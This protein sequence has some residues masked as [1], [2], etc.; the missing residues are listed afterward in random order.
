MTNIPIALQLYSVRGD[1]ENDLAATLKSVADLG[2]VGAEPWGYG[3]ESLDWMGHACQDIRAMYDDNGLTCCGIHLATGALMGDNL[4]RTIE[5]NRAL[6]NNFL[7][8]AADK[9][10]MSAVDTI[11]ELAGILNAAAEKVQPEGMF[12]GYHAHGF[13]F[14][15]V[16]GREPWDILFSSTGDDVI[17]QMDIGNCMGGGGDP[18]A[19]LRKFTNRARSLHLKDH[20]AP[21]DGVIGEGAADWEEIFRLVDTVQ[22]TEWFVVE[23]GGRDGHGF[24]VCRRSLEALRAMGK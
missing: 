8:I 18:V 15:K 16:A 22:N 6:G 5:F 14:K 23:E 19:Y 4:A 20:G 10:R 11:M 17:M 1:V 7:I 21:Q 12:V 13:D 9:P 2:Y 24:E 3:G